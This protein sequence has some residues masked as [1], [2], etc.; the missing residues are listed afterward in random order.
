[1]PEDTKVQVSNNQKSFVEILIVK[2][3]GLCKKVEELSVI[4]SSPDFQYILKNALISASRSSCKEVHE[5]LVSLLVERIN[6]DDSELERVIYNDAISMVPRLTRNQISMLCL[7]FLIYSY[8][9]SNIS[10]LD[11]LLDF[12]RRVYLPFVPAYF[13]IWRR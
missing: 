9:N 11:E 2:L 8:K 7:I 10:T 12:L 4:V 3:D 6:N 13:I 1:M 5:R